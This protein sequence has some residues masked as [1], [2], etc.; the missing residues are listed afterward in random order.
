MLEVP[1]TCRALEGIWGVP[2]IIHRRIIKASWVFVPMWA[3]LEAN[4]GQ[5]PLWG[6][7]GWDGREAVGVSGDQCCLS[8]QGDAAPRC[9]QGVRSKTKLGNRPQ[10]GN[11]GAGWVSAYALN[12]S[13]KL[14]HR[15]GQLLGIKFI[16]AEWPRTADT[17]LRILANK[18]HEALAGAFRVT[19]CMGR[20]RGSWA[21]DLGLPA[22]N[23]P[24]AACWPGLVVWE[25]FRA[26]FLLTSPF[27][28]HQQVT[29]EMPPRDR[30]P[31][32]GNRPYAGH[33]TAPKEKVFLCF[34][35]RLVSCVMEGAAFVHGLPSLGTD[36][37]GAP[38]LEN[39]PQIITEM[40][41]E[42]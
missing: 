41:K 17:S 34:H 25:M 27:M 1:V 4:L 6:V 3:G 39:S 42:I 11:V 22:I 21:N 15:W 38:R 14:C 16:I 30:S 37:T 18:E 24:P 9:Q 36:N 26:Q 28:L 19:A 2:S 5:K 13:T 29:G 40:D 10:G 12:V 35:G 8:W 7:S 31:A 32:R 33:G 23:E 20:R